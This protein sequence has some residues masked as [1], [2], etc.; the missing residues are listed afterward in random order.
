[1]ESA[2]SQELM[3]SEWDEDVAPEGQT[4]G[5]GVDKPCIYAHAHGSD[6]DPVGVKIVMYHE[7]EV[8]HVLLIPCIAALEDTVEPVLCPEA[9]AEVG[10]VTDVTRE[11]VCAPASRRAHRYAATHIKCDAADSAHCHVQQHL[12]LVV[13]LT[14]AIPFPGFLILRQPK[15]APMLRP[16]CRGIE[17]QW[18]DERE[19]PEVLCWGS[20]EECVLH[21]VWG[22]VEC[23]CELRGIMCLSEE[24]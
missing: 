23:L 7:R 5:G 11:L 18:V 1:M 14:P 16:A 3:E 21:T 10:R 9:R 17:V 20:G 19:A 13:L 4:E 6:T 12:A 2:R 8:R 15:H 24:S 22:E